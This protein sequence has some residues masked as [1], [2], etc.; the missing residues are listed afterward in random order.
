MFAADNWRALRELVGTS[1]TVHLSA[2]ADAEGD[3][4]RP[5]ATYTGCHV[6]AAGA[7]A[8]ATAGTL[9]AVVLKLSGGERKK[10]CACCGENK[11]LDDFCRRTD[12]PD[13]REYRCKR[14]EA[15]RVAEYTAK[16]TEAR[17]KVAAG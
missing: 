5:D 15:A 14:C 13:G 11:P 2:T 10:T 6:G 17:R 8:R 3:P 9:E 4:D 1:G 16:R 12:L 7:V